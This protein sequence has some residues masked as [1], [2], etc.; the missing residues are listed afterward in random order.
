MMHLRCS[1]GEYKWAWRCVEAVTDPR[2]VVVGVCRAET[3]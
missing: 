2:T 3:R 1:F